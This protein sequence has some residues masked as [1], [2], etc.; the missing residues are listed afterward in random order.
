MKRKRLVFSAVAVLLLAVLV[1]YVLNYRGKT[2]IRVGND[3]ERIVVTS[4]AF[5]DLGVIPTA[6]T[7]NG[8]DISP[9]FRLE[10]LSR[11]AKSIAIIMDDLDI[12]LR[13]N[14]THWTIWN[15][16]PQADIPEGIPPGETVEALGATQGMGY[17]MHRYRGPKPPFG[18]H[19]YQFHFFVLN[20]ML[21]MNAS[22][23][24][25]ELLRAIDKHLLQYGTITGWYPRAR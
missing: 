5:E 11:D 12:P 7:G 13:G 24:K 17:G 2:D 20:E 10:G 22:A 14:Y 8:A 1:I 6:Y 3:V 23:G 25:E 16:P 4:T 15:L 9:P 19:R 18:T 21:P